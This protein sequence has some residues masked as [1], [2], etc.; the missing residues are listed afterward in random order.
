MPITG[1]SKR[2]G[3]EKKKK[4]THTHSRTK[5]FSSAS[6]A[7]PS[8]NICVPCTGAPYLKVAAVRRRLEALDDRLHSLRVE[9]KPGHVIV[10]LVEILRSGIADI[11]AAL[12][13]LLHAR[14]VLVLDLVQAM[15][16][17]TAPT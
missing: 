2:L 3:L 6:A 1:Q 14:V 15:F 11:A 10:L 8:R 13:E 9:A 7:S 12:Q 16:L 17:H 5:T 4:K